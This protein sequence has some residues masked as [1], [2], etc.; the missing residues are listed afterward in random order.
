MWKGY[1]MFYYI[2]G[3]ALVADANTVVI[4]ANG[5]GYSLTVSG[6]TL[7]KVSN[8]SGKVK[9]F[10]YLSVKED[11]IELFGFH[12]LEELNLFKLLILVSGV[13]PKV[14]MSILS[15]FTPASFAATLASDDAKA[16]SRANGVGAKTAS[17]IILEL[18]DKVAKQFTADEASASEV[19]SQSST[20]MVD[21][22]NALLVLG[23]T[24]S[25]ASSV[26]A[27]IDS[28]GMDTEELIKEALKRLMK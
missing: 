27:K 7:G 24:R 22:K 9:L 18:K 8:T 23:Y 11:G 16:I 26:L 17:R 3:E 5:V 1:G 13:G 21:A 20:A 15:V 28:T 12:S 2:C 4:D 25:E 19:I 14:A 10:T 6:N